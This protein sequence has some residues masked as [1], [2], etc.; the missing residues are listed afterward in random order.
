[1]FYMFSLDRPAVRQQIAQRV[2]VVGEG[3][4]DPL[5]H[6]GRLQRPFRGLLRVPAD[7]TRGR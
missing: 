6:Q 7:V 3:E 4:I 1:M 2:Q 5:E